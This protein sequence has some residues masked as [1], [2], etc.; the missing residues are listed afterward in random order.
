MISTSLLLFAS[1]ASH[2]GGT[3]NGFLGL[4]VEQVLQHPD[5]ASLAGFET[6]RLYANLEDG[7]SITSVYGNASGNLTISLSEG[8]FY[9]SPFGGPTSQDIDYIVLPFSPDLEW[10][11]YVTIGCI[12]TDGD[13]FDSNNLGYVGVNWTQFDPLGGSLFVDNGAWFS[14]T[15]PQ[16]REINGKVFLGQF[17]IPV[18]ATFDAV[19]NLQGRNVA[20][21]VWNYIGASAQY[22]SS[23]VN[24]IC[25]GNANSTGAGASL[26][27]SGS[28]EVVNNDTTLELT[29]LPSNQAVL[30]VNSRETI[31]VANPGGSQGDLCIGSLAM[32]RHVNDILDSGASGAASL[33]LDLA[34]VPTNLGRTAVLAGE[35]WYWQAWYRDVDGG[36]APT[37][38]FSSAISVTFD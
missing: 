21:E 25:I 27:A 7:G 38:N 28:F 18:G 29:G 36:G 31:L 26:T 5:S 22:T 13:P 17:T 19:I 37:S 24:V 20:D 33:A 9:Q 15:S 2:G 35:I 1:I 32:G 16:T 11:S 14:I 4:S 3:S 6:I 10:D 23:S 12:N 8:A 30:L 34:N